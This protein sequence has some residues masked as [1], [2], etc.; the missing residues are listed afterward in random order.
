MDVWMDGWRDVF[1]GISFPA[2]S[3]DFKDEKNRLLV[4]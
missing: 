2:V 1:K 3:T 4:K